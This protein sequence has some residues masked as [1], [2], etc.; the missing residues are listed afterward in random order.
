MKMPNQSVQTSYALKFE[1]V[2]NAQLNAHDV[3]GT[4]L[5]GTPSV[6]GLEKLRV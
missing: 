2:Q 3:P 1:K 6:P 5:L 4:G